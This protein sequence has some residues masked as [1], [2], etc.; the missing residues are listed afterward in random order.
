M[1][2]TPLQIAHPPDPPSRP[3]QFKYNK[4]N[5]KQQ[6]DAATTIPAYAAIANFYMKCLINKL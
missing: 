2:L 6:D 1:I 3:Q 4:S 5:Y